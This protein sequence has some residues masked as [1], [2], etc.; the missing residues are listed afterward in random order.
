MVS[1]SFIATSLY[2]Q[3]EL[4]APSDAPVTQSA[5]DS[6][7]PPIEKNEKAEPPITIVAD[8]GFGENKL[9][10]NDYFRAESVSA[11]VDKRG[12]IDPM[13]DH[14][15]LIPTAFTPKQFSFSLTTTNFFLNSLSFS[16]TDDLQLSTTFLVPTGINDF[17]LNASGKMRLI[18]DENYI[19]SAQPFVSYQAGEE[20]LDVTNFGIGGGLLA[21]FYL[22]DRFVL[23]TGSFLFLN[24]LNINDQLNYDTCTTHKDFVDGTCINTDKETSFP[25]GGHWLSLHASLIYY[26]YDSFSLR[27]E[28]ISGITSGSFLGTE[29]VNGKDPF[30]EKK[31]NFSD[32]SIGLGIPKDSIITLG[33]GIA[34]SRKNIGFKASSYLWR[35]EVRTND[36]FD[37]LS[38]ED[39]WVLSPTI[40]ATIGF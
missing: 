8:P 37:N 17:M 28:A 31:A 6:Q 22:S 26:I 34:W 24:I 7:P 3:E 32:P 14:S 18:S 11:P 29:Y 25:A 27:F 5:D 38:I 9:I 23:S 21:D 1:L 10:S 19:V 39:K 2:A 33:A 15:I 36:A 4:S 16:P 13:S 30:S 12:K 40:S 20:D 35:T